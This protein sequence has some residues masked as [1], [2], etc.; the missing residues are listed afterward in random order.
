[1]R[2]RRQLLD[3]AASTFLE[4]GYEG[5]SIGEITSRAGLT[6]GA[7][8]FHFTSKEELAQ[9]VL[10]E[11][12]TTEGVGPQLLKLQELVDAAMALAYRLPRE[13]VLAAALRLA[14]DNGVRRGVRTAW[15][16]WIAL[17]TGMLEEAKRSGETLPHVDAGRT[18]RLVMS[19]WTGA[20]LV[21]DRVPDGH[22]LEHHIGT[23]L[24]HLLPS[25]AVPAVLA[26]L[27]TAAG[28]GAR[29]VAAAVQ[30]APRLCSPVGT[31]VRAPL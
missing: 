2:T 7:V 3:A 10:D 25:I 31:G 6:R 12:V 13:P 22:D 17:L 18:A 28:R 16:E 26:R 8:Y 5:A 30:D 9:G 24:D 29:L 23:L 15:P 27:D 4:Y 11:A 1:M 19:S 14:V 20:A 21:L